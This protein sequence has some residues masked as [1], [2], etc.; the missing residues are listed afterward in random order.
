M[1]MVDGNSDA[2]VVM[3]MKSPNAFAGKD[4]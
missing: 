2:G 1:S 3:T 4:R